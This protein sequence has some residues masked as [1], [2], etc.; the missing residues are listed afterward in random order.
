[1]ILS[2]LSLLWMP[3]VLI[4]KRLQRLLVLVRQLLQSGQME[5]ASVFNT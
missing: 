2:Q 1:M 4:R 5:V 3:M